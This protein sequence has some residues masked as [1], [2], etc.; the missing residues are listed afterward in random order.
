MRTAHPVLTCEPV[1]VILY[2]LVLSTESTT[3][4]PRF[5]AVLAVM[6]GGCQV[7]RR[8]PHAYGTTAARPPPS[9]RRY[10]CVWRKG[11]LNGYSKY[12]RLAMGFANVR[13][14]RYG[15][16]SCSGGYS[17][18]NALVLVQARDA[19]HA[20]LFPTDRFAQFHES[21]VEFEFDVDNDH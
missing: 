6:H 14:S 7:A 5:T 21:A 3:L 11:V 17:S 15:I 20:Q 8:D 4:E 13:A 10:P 9:T 18:T 16:R 12:A 19:R 2:F 1:N